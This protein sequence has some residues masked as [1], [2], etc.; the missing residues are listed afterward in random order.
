MN[1]KGIAKGLIGAL[2][3]G[4]FAG[5]LG[6]ILGFCYGVYQGSSGESGHRRLDGDEGTEPV[7]SARGARLLFQCLGK[8]AKSD[9]HVSEDEAAF[10]KS[11]MKNWQLDATT[12]RRFALE[13]NFGRDS[14]E[15][16]LFFVQNLA[17]ELESIRATRAMRKVIV[18]VFCSLVVADRYVHPEERRM[19]REAGRVLGV[20]HDVDAFFAGYR[21]ESAQQ[22][23]PA[24]S[25]QDFSP[26]RC[27]EILGIPPTATDA[28]VKSAYRRKA[29]ECHPDL[30]EGAGLSAATI[31]RAKESFQRIGRAY[32]TIRQL[33][34]MK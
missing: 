30:A 24:S 1:F 31:Q 7:L 6:A 23:P 8:L 34:G 3:G 27:Y 14:S 9:G 20:Q 25:S 33:R 32:D 5:P 19:L 17:R 12:R 13:F 11:I 4:F 18:Q 16:F 2:I 29:K 21:N 10:V 26:E 15:P 22:P 28:Q